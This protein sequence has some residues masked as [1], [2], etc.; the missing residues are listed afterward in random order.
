VIID[1]APLLTVADTAEIVPHTS[2]VLLCVRLRQTTQDQ[3]RATDAALD[4]LPVPPVGVVLTDVKEMS[5][6]YYG[7]Y[8]RRT[9]EEAGSG[10]SGRE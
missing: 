4:R 7:Y 5:E 8:Y 3:V 10:S 1:S 9:P 2:G 6:R